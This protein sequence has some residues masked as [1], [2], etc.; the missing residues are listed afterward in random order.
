MYPS[1]NDVGFYISESHWFTDMVVIPIAI[2]DRIIIL[3]YAHASDGGRLPENYAQ[4]LQAMCTAAGSSFVR[5]IQ[6][7]KEGHKPTT[8]LPL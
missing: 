2:A 4:E 5:L 8:L 6:Q 3:V 7:A 1:L